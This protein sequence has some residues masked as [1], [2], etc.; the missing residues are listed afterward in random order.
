MVVEGLVDMRIRKG[1]NIR[2]MAAKAV[3]KAA[4]AAVDVAR[5]RR[6]HHRAGESAVE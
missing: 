6:T 4:K 1:G 3:G 5:L 2:E